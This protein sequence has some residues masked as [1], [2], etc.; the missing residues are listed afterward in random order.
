[1]HAY[2]HAFVYSIDSGLGWDLLI[3]GWGLTCVLTRFFVT[4]STRNI[5]VV[6]VARYL[7]LPSVGRHN[8]ANIYPD[9]P[10]VSAQGLTRRDC[11]LPAA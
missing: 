1:M 5:I 8:R 6:H 4:R 7:T 3:G 11:I 9:M 10:R 2:T